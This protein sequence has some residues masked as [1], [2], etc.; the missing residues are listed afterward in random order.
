[1]CCDRDGVFSAAEYRNLPV[2]SG[3]LRLPVR[4]LRR[5]SY[6]KV[7]RGELTGT[8]GRSSGNCDTFHWAGPVNRSVPKGVRRQELPVGV[9]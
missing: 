8:L 2:S 3:L 7:F 4:T 5:I 6:V 1:M 9:T